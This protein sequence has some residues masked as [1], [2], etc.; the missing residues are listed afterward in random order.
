MARRITSIGL[1]AGISLVLAGTLAAQ[2][3]TAD[4]MAAMMEAVAPDENHAVLEPL[5]G[6]WSHAVT[7]YPAPGAEPMQ[8]TATSTAE[9]TMGGRYLVTEIHG[10]F[11]GTPFEGREVMG[12]DKVKGKYFALFHDNMSTGPVVSWGTWDPATKTMTMEG[13]L[14]DPM[15]G[16]LEKKI[17]NTTQF[18]DDGS[19]HYENWGPGPDG[20]MYKTMEIRSTK[21]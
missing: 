10:D 13:T 17:R 2:D 21:Q 8:M 12:Y 11:L 15:T 16:E 14:A 20:Q 19:V 4:Q 7:F 6:S 9:M 3:P 1:A 18:L 5:A